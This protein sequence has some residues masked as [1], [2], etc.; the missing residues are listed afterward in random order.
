LNAPNQAYAKQ[1]DLLMTTL[2]C[3]SCVTHLYNSGVGKNGGWQD[4]RPA[5]PPTA[6][7]NS[8]GANMCSR[9]GTVFQMQQTLPGTIMAVVKAQEGV[10]QGPTQQRHRTTAGAVEEACASVSQSTVADA[11]GMSTVA[12]LP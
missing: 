1:G 8:W 11:A 5:P 9:K 3:S 12:W 10:S 7:S 4:A 6:S 2:L